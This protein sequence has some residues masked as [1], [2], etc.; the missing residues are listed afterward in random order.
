VKLHIRLGWAAG[1]AGLAGVLLAGSGSAAAPPP[2]AAD[3]APAA[4]GTAA[5]PQPASSRPASPALP[6]TQPSRMCNFTWFRLP[7]RRSAAGR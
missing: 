7:V 2:G 1:I 5:G 3:G 4:D 6:A